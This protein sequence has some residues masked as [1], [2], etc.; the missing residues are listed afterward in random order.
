MFD[1]ASFDPHE[2]VVFAP[3]GVIGVDRESLG[4]ATVESILAKIRRT[5]VRVI[6]FFFARLSA[7]HRPTSELADEMARQFLVE[8][9]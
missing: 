7:A 5:S 4:D 2:R 1:H 6:E 3:G 8:A 9:R